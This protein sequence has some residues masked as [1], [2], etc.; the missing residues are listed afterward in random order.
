LRWLLTGRL[1]RWES[2]LGY[3]LKQERIMKQNATNGGV[4]QHV[5]SALLIAFVTTMVTV[6]TRAAELL[7]S[8]N[9]TSEILRYDGVTGAFTDAFVTAGAGTLNGPAGLV[10]GPDGH[11]Y[12]TSANNHQILRYDGTTG[13]FIDALQ[14]LTTI[15]TFLSRGTG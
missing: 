5:L 6:P 8:S 14:D 15:L 13:A 12:V 9:N 4:F 7:V 2:G 3:L 1:S 10:L 11:L